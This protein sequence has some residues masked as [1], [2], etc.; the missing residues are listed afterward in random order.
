MTTREETKDF[1]H[2]KFYILTSPHNDPI[3]LGK[4]E[5][6]NKFPE[7]YE[8]E[9]Y[10][11]EYPLYQHYDRFYTAQSVF[12]SLT[13]C[14]DYTA[15]CEEKIMIAEIV[16]YEDSQLFYMYQGVYVSDKYN[17]VNIVKMCDYLNNLSIDDQICAVEQSTLVFRHISDPDMRVQ[18]SAIKN[19]DDEIHY[20]KNPSEL[21]KR[22]YIKHRYSS[23]G[24]LI[25]KGFDISGQLE[26]LAIKHHGAR[27]LDNIKNM[28]D[29][30]QHLLIRD[31][32]GIKHILR[33][34]RT[35]S[36][37]IQKYAVA[38]NGDAIK[39]ILQYFI[40][41]KE[42]MKIAIA[43]NKIAEK[44]INKKIGQIQFKERQY[45]L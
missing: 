5:Y 42:V 44:H 34:G 45:L 31:G 35:P 41:S 1:I 4:L 7:L 9:S 8:N 15:N 17:I 27:E 37:E 6:I 38:I 43:E 3:C 23:L 12:E 16:L 11:K 24:V 32:Y 39:Y 30:I 33:S 20:I 29:A 14:Y 18:I 13:Y 10:A 2:K 21:I 22:I 26:F 19:W 36:E 40:P 25:H 28:S